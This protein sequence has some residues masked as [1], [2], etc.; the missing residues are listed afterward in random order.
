VGEGIIARKGVVLPQLD[1]SASV[2]EILVN[3]QMINE[4]G[5][6]VSGKMP[7]NKAIIKNLEVSS[8]QYTIPKGYHNGL[9]KVIAPSF[10]QGCCV[11]PLVSMSDSTMVST[12]QFNLPINSEI[13]SN[14]NVEII[15][16]NT[17]NISHGKKVL[18]AGSIKLNVKIGSTIT[19]YL[20]NKLIYNNINDLLNKGFYSLGK[21][22]YPI[23][24]YGVSVCL[25]NKVY[26]RTMYGVS[27]WNGTEWTNIASFPERISSGALF[28]SGDKLHILARK[29][30]GNKEVHWVWN[31]GENAWFTDI[32]HPADCLAYAIINYNNEVHFIGGYKHYKWNDS[33]WTVVSTL[34]YEFIS[35]VGVYYKNNIYIMGGNSNSYDA[36]YRLDGTTWTSI[37]KIPRKIYMSSGGVHAG[38]IHVLGSF[39]DELKHTTWDGVQWE[40]EN[41]LP[42]PFFNTNVAYDDNGLYIVGGGNGNENFYYY[43]NKFKLYFKSGTKINNEVIMTTGFKEILVEKPLFLE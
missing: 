5:E 10:I 43:T 7:D 34:P 15:N 40:E 31:E 36:F 27:E 22:P 13:Y 3:K 32:T 26:L 33:T 16:G 17:A 19:I 28:S 37:G 18:E 30:N 38:K 42:V 35:G 6:V 2:D 39:E 41:N 29:Y 11:N 20:E 14:E 21:L 9:G 4:F 1:N 8:E 12:Y 23:Y 24:S 25:K